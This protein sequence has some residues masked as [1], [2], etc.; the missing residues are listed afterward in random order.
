MAIYSLSGGMKRI[1]VSTNNAK[2]SLPI[3]TVLQWS[4]YGD[5]QE[6]IIKNMGIDQTYGYGARY[7]CVS[8]KDFSINQHDAMGLTHISERRPGI[9]VSY[10]N[11]IRSGDE[12]VELWEKAQAKIVSTAAAKESHAAAVV[13]IKAQLRADRPELEAVKEGEYP[14]CVLAA[15]NIR[16]ELKRAFP[17]VKF[18]ITSKSYSGGNSV[19][20]HWTDGPTSK[21]V[22]AI[23]SK[24]QQGSFD[25]M[26][27][28]YDYD[29][30][31]CWTDVFGGAKYVQEQRDVTAEA[32]HAAAVRLGY[33]DAVM[34]PNSCNL[35]GVTYDQSEMIKRDA[36]D[37]SCF[38]NK[39]VD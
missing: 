26:T 3:G 35:S 6:V 36:W 30:D 31:R 38:S 11:E 17:G 22:E 4:G 10:T 37:W 2:N 23:T 15:K 9:G 16:T 32:Y 39:T 34:P 27:D 1:D 18:S 21:E 19:D 33:P 28:S 8:L 20:I 5:Y 7:Q 25:G 12:C 24:Y 14:S 13:T 29:S